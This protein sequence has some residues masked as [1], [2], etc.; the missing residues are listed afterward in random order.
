MGHLTRPLRSAWLGDTNYVS[1]YRFGVEQAMALLGHWHRTISIRYSLAVIEQQIAEVHPDI[2]FTHM[3]MWPPPGGPTA[4]ELLVAARRWRQNGAIVLIHDGDPRPTTRFPESV[5]GAVDLAL[6]NHKRPVPEWNIPTLYWPYA[7]LTQNAV[8]TPVPRFRCDLAFAGRLRWDL[9]LYGRRTLTVVELRRRIDLKT[10]PGPDGINNRMQIADLAPSAN[11]II[12]FGRPEREGWI[13][14][15]VFSVPG[16]GGV[17]VHDDA[18]VLEPNVHF[19]P[20]KLYDVDSVIEAVE[21]AKD[22]ATSAT[23]RAEAFKLIQAKHTWV[24]RCQQVLD[25][26]FK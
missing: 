11:A 17:L 23:I 6:L 13:D 16:A 3:L 20:C 14:T 10:F 19:L 12:G 24:H 25:L 7:A 15:R 22:D 2:I 9:K 4:E 1:A 18:P 8:G 5:E 21:Q 26:F